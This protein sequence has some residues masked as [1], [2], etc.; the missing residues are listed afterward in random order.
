MYHCQL[1]CFIDIASEEV[2]SRHEEVPSRHEEVPSRHE[3][4]P[5]RHE[6]VPSRHEEVPSR[7][8]EVPSRHE[9]VPNRYDEV[10]SALKLYMHDLDISGLNFDSATTLIKSRIENH[11]KKSLEDGIAYDKVDRQIHDFMINALIPADIFKWC[12]DKLE[13][14]KKVTE[15]SED[16]SAVSPKTPPDDVPPLFCK[17]VVHHASI[18]C[19]VITEVSANKALSLE[20]VFK[21]QRHNFKHVS[22]SSNKLLLMAEKDDVMYF[23]FANDH[24]QAT[25]IFCYQAGYNEMSKNSKQFYII[26]FHKQASLRHFYIE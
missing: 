19:N 11:I 21:K 13:E 6:E 8:E 12:E 5:S 15:S 3:E 10:V 7:H 17:D 24:T 1:F 14:Y 4:V 9:E 16:A 25:R 2:P 18:C 26:L 23:A 22:L 20:A